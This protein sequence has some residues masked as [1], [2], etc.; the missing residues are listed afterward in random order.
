MD[1]AQILIERIIRW[2]GTYITLIK[3]AH[4]LRGCME[5]SRNTN[6]AWMV[7]AAPVG[8]LLTYGDENNECAACRNADTWGFGIQRA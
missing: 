6:P 5:H 7:M 8:D 4:Q 3:S 1:A 2:K